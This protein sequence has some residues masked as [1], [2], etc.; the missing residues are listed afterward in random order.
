MYQTVAAIV[1]HY[2]DFL[3]CNFLAFRVFST[4][5]PIQKT[6]AEVWTTGTVSGSLGPGEA[7]MA[8][9]APWPGRVIS[10]IRSSLQGDYDPVVWKWSLKVV[11][12][13]HVELESR[14]VDNILVSDTTG[15][16]FINRLCLIL[17][18]KWVSTYCNF[19]R[20]YSSSGTF[21]LPVP[22]KKG[23]SDCQ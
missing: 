22:I 23:H 11:R 2:T 1:G 14:N 5:P 8:P 20:V 4:V 18:H 21:S 16:S 17:G 9:A 3:K 15:A 7:P 13:A 19:C 12:H 6:H 10:R